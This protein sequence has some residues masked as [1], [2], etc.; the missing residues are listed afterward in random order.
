MK[1]CHTG[2]FCG[3]ETSNPISLLQLE[4]QVDLRQV[5]EAEGA[6]CL[7]LRLLL[8]LQHQLQLSHPPAGVDSM[9]VWDARQD[10]GRQST[11]DSTARPGF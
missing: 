9:Q 11:G 7:D 5:L 8:A 2:M 6:Q 3:H 10:Q 1:Q 4:G